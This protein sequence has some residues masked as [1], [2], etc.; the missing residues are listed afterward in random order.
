MSVPVRFL[1]LN[2]LFWVS[3]VVWILELQLRNL[4]DIYSILNPILF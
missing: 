2:K 4:W 1:L 3:E